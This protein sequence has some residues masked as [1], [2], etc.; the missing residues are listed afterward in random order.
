M[1]QGG[2]IPVGMDVLTGK[3]DTL[4]KCRADPGDVCEKLEDLVGQKT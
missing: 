3:D 4:E 1:G 2:W